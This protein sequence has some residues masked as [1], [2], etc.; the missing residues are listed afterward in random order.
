MKRKRRGPKKVSTPRLRRATLTL[1]SRAVRAAAGGKC[2]VCGCADGSLNDKGNPRRLN[3]HH[4]EDKA[5]QALR[6]DPMNGVALCPT[7]HKFG[8]DS[9]H[10]SPLWFM[11][12]LRN[13][14]PVRY[15]YVKENRTASPPSRERLVELAQ[16]LRSILHE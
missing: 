10:R 2:E 6:F 15:M 11:E 16:T 13:N 5:C 9:A 4:I 7:C 8:P 1:W 3:A 12:W 14:R